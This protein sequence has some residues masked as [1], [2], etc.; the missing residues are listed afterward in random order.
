MSKEGKEIEYSE[1]TQINYVIDNVFAL[2]KKMMV[3]SGND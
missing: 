2:L 1:K 3:I